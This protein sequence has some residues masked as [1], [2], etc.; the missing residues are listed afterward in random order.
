MSL[1]LIHGMSPPQK[2][3]SEV[4]GVP[5]LEVRPR[6]PKEVISQSSGSGP[7][8][9]RSD[10]SGLVAN[11]SGLCRRWRCV[12][13]M[14]SLGP[15][16]RLSARRIA[17]GRA[18][19]SP[20]RTMPTRYVEAGSPRSWL[21]PCQARYVLRET[22]RRSPGR[23]MVRADTSTFVS[24]TT[25]T[26]A[27]TAADLPRSGFPAPSPV[28]SSNPAMPPALPADG[29]PACSGGRPERPSST[30]FPPPE[31]SARRRGRDREAG[32]WSSLRRS[33]S[34]QR[35]PTRAELGGEYILDP[36]RRWKNAIA[37]ATPAPRAERPGSRLAPAD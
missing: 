1:E 29:W 26:P 3:A 11:A 6:D 28:D 37:D 16:S 7:H 22:M 19:R 13:F 5:P 25:L 20:I 30:P 12:G 23:V 8:P 34:L 27:G 36:T 21:Y 4:D 35:S 10:C 18:G 32:R 15:S 24:N 9:L 17:I 33:S 31:R 14:C 2:R